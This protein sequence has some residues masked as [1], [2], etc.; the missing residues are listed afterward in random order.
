MGRTVGAQDKRKRR[1][2][3]FYRGFDH[4]LRR[5]LDNIAHL[6]AHT[7][8]SR[9]ARKICFA[10]VKAEQDG[11]QEV[12]VMVL[13][14]G[15]HFPLGFE[16]EALQRLQ[17]SAARMAQFLEACNFQVRVQRNAQ[18]QVVLIAAWHEWC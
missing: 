4:V 18:R 7:Q 8:L 3:L 17:H 5:L 13:R 16:H 14:P 2:R 11:L 12:E 1:S 15:T 9:T 10:C 6:K